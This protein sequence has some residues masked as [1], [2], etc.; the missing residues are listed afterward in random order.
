L[1]FEDDNKIVGGHD[2]QAKDAPFQVAMLNKGRQICGGS[3]LDENTVMTAAHCCTGGAHSLTVG[4]GSVMLD[5]V[6]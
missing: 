1:D 2:A 4:Y 3:I 5:D 6:G